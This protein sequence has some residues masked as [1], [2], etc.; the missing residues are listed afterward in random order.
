[1]RRWEGRAREDLAR[2]EEARAEGN[3]GM[4]RVCSRRAVG[5]AAKA[6]L[7]VKGVEK[8]KASGFENILQLVDEGL[9]GSET[10]NAIERLT[11]NLESE[12]AQGEEVWPKELDLVADARAVISALFPEFS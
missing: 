1:M 3:E 9:V 8:I 5:W 6:Y 10:E 12:N 11:S 2:A 4:V 7:R